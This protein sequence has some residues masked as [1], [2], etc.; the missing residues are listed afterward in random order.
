[1]KT[2][3]NLLVAAVLLLRSLT[4]AGETAPKLPPEYAI[5]HIGP[6]F[7]SFELEEYIT[8][9][10]EK[11]TPSDEAELRR[12]IR[13]G[14]K[15]ATF[16]GDKKYVTPREMV[17]VT[18]DDKHGMSPGEWLPYEVALPHWS[19]M[20][21]EE[22]DTY[23][24]MFEKTMKSGE[25]YTSMYQN[26]SSLFMMVKDFYGNGNIKTKFIKSMDGSKVGIEYRYNDKGKLI[27]EIDHERGWGFTTAD[28][29]K[30][31]YQ[32]EI[33]V[34]AEA[35]IEGIP[36]EIDKREKDG[37]KYWHITSFVM[38][39]DQAYHNI[40]KLDG[41]TGKQIGETEEVHIGPW[42]LK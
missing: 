26:K 12:L 30:F 23:R 27:R 15:N 14:F 29:M 39:L 32:N 36:L 10:E 37:K 40:Y 19:K 22:T 7:E 38:K 24:S 2:Y 5:P 3:F 8:F 13:V 41:A 31:C 42:P 25:V 16:T 4:F 35:E 28:V 17:N 6:E 34:R 20:K 21:S 1:M 33:A 18:A 9:L 11:S